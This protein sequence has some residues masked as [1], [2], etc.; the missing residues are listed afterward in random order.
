MGIM[1]R[2]GM[3]ALCLAAVLSGRGQT[4]GMVQKV[5]ESQKVHRK[6]GGQV[7]KTTDSTFFSS[8]E[9]V[10]VGEQ[11]LLYQ[12]QTGGWPKNIDMA[13]LLTDDERR[14]VAAQQGR[15][16][17]STI[18][19]GATTM[20]MVFLARLY[21][22][23]GDARFRDAFGRA[24]GYLLCGQ[25]ENGG[26]PQF[27]PNPRGYQRHITF[28]DDA[29]TNVL[30]LLRQVAD[31]VAPFD[32]SLADETTRQRARQAFCRGIDCILA[33]Q[34]VCDGRPT[35]WCQQHDSATLKPA[36]ARSY[37]LPSFCSTESAAIVELL[38]S[39]P[40]PDERIVRAVEGAMR[41]FDEHKITGFRL[42]R[43]PDTHLVADSLAEPLWARF[44][45]LQ[46]GIPFFCDRDGVPRTCLEDVGQ[47]RRNGYAWYGSRPLR[48]YGMYERWRAAQSRGGL[49]QDR[50]SR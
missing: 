14:A 9:A 6:T 15:T 45:D 12:R 29:M 48:L 47:E 10:R 42:V 30:S 27:W 22:H 18:D 35:V 39:L 4:G 34:I 41:W 8:A 32:G 26:W 11:L 43:T 2:M 16:D 7:L 33:T 17:D 38:M 5:D 24:L 13:A 23:T 46:T 19:N 49:S 40:S 44:Y 21:R 36:G 50:K 37:E 20:Q 28:N 31:G 1:M 3:M 25:Y